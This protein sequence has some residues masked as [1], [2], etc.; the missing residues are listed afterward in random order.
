MR[1]LSERVDFHH[2]DEDEFRLQM[3]AHMEQQ[4]KFLGAI[5]D[6]LNSVNLLFKVISIIVTAYGSWTVVNTFVKH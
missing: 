4:T 5:Y 3:C 2:M 1:Q 6:V